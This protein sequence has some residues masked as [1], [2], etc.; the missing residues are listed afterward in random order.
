MSRFMNLTPLFRWGVKMIKLM[1]NN[2]LSEEEVEKLSFL[3][4]LRLFVTQTNY[5][6]NVLEKIQSH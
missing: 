4:P 5:I 6:L 2:M 3:S 1:D